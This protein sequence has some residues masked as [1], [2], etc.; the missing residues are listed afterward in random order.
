MTRPALG[1]YAH[2][3]WCARICPYCDFNVYRAKGADTDAMTAAL[4]GHVGLWAEHMQPRPL[5]SLHFG[6]GTPSLAPPVTIAAVIKAADARFG[7]A[8]DAEIGLEANPE[9]ADPERWRDF[10]DAGVERVS[11][12]V[13][14]LDDDALKSLGRMHSADQA[15]RAIALALEIFPRVSIDLIY[16]R[17]DQTAEAWEAELEETLGFGL[18]HLSAYQ[19]TIEPGTAFEKR[20][21]RGQLDTPEEDSAAQ[22]YEITQQICAARGLP[23]YEV[24]NHASGPAHQSR[25]NRL[26]WTSQDWIAIGPGGHGRLWA[27]GDARRGFALARRPDAYQAAVSAGELWE[28]DE[29]LSPL[30]AARE[31]ILMGLRIT[32]GL[33]RARLRAATGQDVDADAL[34]RLTGQGL[35]AGDETRIKAT[36]KGRPV[37]D[38]VAGALCP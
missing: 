26:Y 16:A 19:L 3:P 25:H 32:D 33:D 21:A 28:E 13:Q 4:T 22:F 27:D 12:G 5:A 38:Y 1:L 35:V 24:S 34:A 20:A 11:L 30:D 14:A 31:M 37:L 7:F 36:R 9:D 18:K 10:R 29:T 6:G 23:A 17:P 15:R 8:P 2:W